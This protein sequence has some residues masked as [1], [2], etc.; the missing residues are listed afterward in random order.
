MKN[1]IIFLTKYNSYFVFVFLEVICFYLIINYNNKQKEIFLYSSNQISG[2][3]LDNYSQ[4]LQYTELKSENQR[5]KEENAQ[6]I[7][8]F[9][10]QKY[11]EIPNYTP[12][13]SV[14]KGINVISAN[15][16]N[17]SIDK[18]NNRMTIDI[19]Y[20]KG[21]HEGMG[22]IGDKG[23]VGVVT[24]VNK[25]Y[26]SILPLNNTLSRTSVIIKNRGY[27]GLL[28]W[29]P[30]DYT[31]TTLTT[32]PKHAQIA[33]GDSIITSGFSTIFPRGIYIGKIEKIKYS[34]SSMY[35]DIS[36]KLINNLA[37]IENVYLI[38]R[39]NKNEIFEIEKVENSDYEPI[40]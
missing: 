36:V 12:N 15:I 20:K 25:N 26:S 37:L 27:F 19:G 29:E 28:K 23:I 4:I 2:F 39:P 24:F 38:E 40:Q 18:R 11:L 7:K 10:N 30:Y 16:C 13:D 31:H 1:L 34:N 3:V 32:I 6:I 5:L 33:V 17:K 35:Y 14:M 9:F 8:N 22:V 21:V